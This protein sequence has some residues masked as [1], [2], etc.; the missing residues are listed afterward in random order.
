MMDYPMRKTIRNW[1]LFWFIAG[2][3]LAMSLCAQTA[4]TPGS[5]VQWYRKP[6]AL[7]P[8]TF[9][10]LFWFKADK[11]ATSDGSTQCTD[12]QHVYEFL[13]QSTTP[14]FD[15]AK[16]V[17]SLLPGHGGTWYSTNGGSNNCP[18]VNVGQAV[19]GDPYRILNV[20]KPTGT[21]Q[22]FT[23]YMTILQ[24]NTG[25]HQII[26]DAFSTDVP[27]QGTPGAWQMYAGT[28][29]SLP[30]FSPN[31]GWHVITAVYN[32]NSSI[33][34]TNGVQLAAGAAGANGAALMY[35][36]D[37]QGSGHLFLGDMTE[38]MVYYGAHNLATM[39]Q[40]ENYLKQRIGL[41]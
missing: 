14:G 24:T 11:D 30:G 25:T 20:G 1:A 2:W 31:V 19:S 3:M 37:Y 38:I 27:I 40:N 22:P 35:F 10:L 7:Q 23:V 33:F 34:R 26:F 13:N 29:L 15:Q 36:Y 4:T 5:G 41:P 18:Y 9:D 17:V 32:G 28:A 21:N 12:G 8:T 6:I 16:L 39:Q